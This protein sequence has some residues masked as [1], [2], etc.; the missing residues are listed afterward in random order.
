M[1]KYMNSNYINNLILIFLIFG[2]IIFLKVCNN[3]DI[4]ETM[5]IDPPSYLESHKTCP[6]MGG[7]TNITGCIHYP[8]LNLGFICSVCCSSCI[9]DIQR[10]FKSEDREYDILIEDN[11]YYL[12]KNGVIKQEVLLCNYNNFKTILDLLGTKMIYD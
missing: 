8:R 3:Q 10:S 7:D 9:S 12:T 11:K 1:Y 6:V 5:T 2:T 4:I